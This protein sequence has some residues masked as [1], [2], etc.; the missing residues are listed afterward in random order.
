LEPSAGKTAASAPPPSAH[1]AVSPPIGDA[2][3]R[4][5]EAPQGGGAVSYERGT[6][7]IDDAFASL[8]QDAANPPHGA[9]AKP[10]ETRWGFEDAPEAPRVVQDPPVFLGDRSGRQEGDNGSGRQKGDSAFVSRQ[11]GDNAAAPVREDAGEDE[12]MLG[13]ASWVTFE[14]PVELNLSPKP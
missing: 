11:E 4:D 7:V 2:E 1:A 3:A 13:K 6:P 8:L 9:A 10:L 12:E 14:D 5:R